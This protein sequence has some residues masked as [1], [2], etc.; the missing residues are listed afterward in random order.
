MQNS[1]VQD[2]VVQQTKALRRATFSAP[3]NFEDST[4]KGKRD[5]Y[6]EEFKEQKLCFDCSDNQWQA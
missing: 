5:E 3:K 1:L 6:L 4:Q 2:D